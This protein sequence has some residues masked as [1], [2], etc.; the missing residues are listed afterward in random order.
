MLYPYIIPL[1]LIAFTYALFTTPIRAL[2]T[3]ALVLFGFSYSWTLSVST[4]DFTVARLS[5]WQYYSTWHFAVPRSISS[6]GTAGTL[7]YWFITGLSF[8][9]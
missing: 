2:C 5:F 1:T 9:R 7:W 8:M 4:Y 6:D 3:Y